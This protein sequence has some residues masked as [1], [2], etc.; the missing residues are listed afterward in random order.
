[1]K[2]LI[3]LAAIF[4]AAG[5]V[6]GAITCPA[7]PYSTYTA[8]GFSCEINGAFF[9]NFE[10]PATPNGGDLTPGDITVSPLSAL[11]S[12]GLRFSANFSAT[13]TFDGPGNSEG[14]VAEQYRF[15]FDVSVPGGVFTDATANIAGGSLF[16]PNAQKPSGY[17]VGLVV[18]NDGAGAFVLDDTPGQTD[19]QALNTARTNIGID[20]TAQVGGGAS[21]SSTGGPFGTGEFDS[22]DNV[23]QYEITPVP[24]P[25]SAVMLAMAGAIGLLLRGRH[26]TLF[27]C[28]RRGS[29]HHA[30]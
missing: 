22:F 8:L 7:A 5:R 13:G 12:V 15:F 2:Y 29:D 24:E 21:N 16:S 1:M 26:T 20:T 14:Q 10:F 28:G 9:S 11:D 18:A 19:T 4:I 17:F 25:G 27:K 30:A 6:Q 23:F 3:A